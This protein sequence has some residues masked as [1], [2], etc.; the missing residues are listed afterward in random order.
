MFS[1]R[2]QHLIFYVMQWDLGLRFCVLNLVSIRYVWLIKRY[3]ILSHNFPCPMS[4]KKLDLTTN[5]GIFVIR[6]FMNLWTR[7][8]HFVKKT[9]TNIS[10]RTLFD[11]TKIENNLLIWNSL[12]QFKMQVQY[13]QLIT[14]VFEIMDILEFECSLRKDL[15]PLGMLNSARADKLHLQFSF[16]FSINVVCDLTFVLILFVQQ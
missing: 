12:K 13:V 9:S 3:T 15:N 16:F 6:N 2:K 8:F 10:N 11:W 1:K 14:I 7:L 5:S 4:G